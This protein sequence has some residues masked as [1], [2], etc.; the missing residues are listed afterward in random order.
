ME[1]YIMEVTSTKWHSLRLREAE[2]NIAE[3]KW[4]VNNV[5]LPELLINIPIQSTWQL[6]VNELI[7]Y[8][9]FACI[10]HLKESKK[11]SRAASQIL[12]SCRKG[13]LYKNC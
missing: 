13:S 7:Y 11:S 8:K 3:Q 1:G 10:Q 4:R 12:D 9:G 5:T 6:K 2:H